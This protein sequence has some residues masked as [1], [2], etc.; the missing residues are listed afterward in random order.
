MASKN[1]G[2][3]AFN[4]NLR[5]MIEKAKQAGMTK[6]NIERAIKRG[7]GELGGAVFEEVIYEIY[8]PGGVGIIVEAVTDNKNRIV[9]DLRSLLN[10]YNGKL[11]NSGSVNFLFEKQGIITIKCS[12]KERD[13]IS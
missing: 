9:A 6:E 2:D 8:G 12:S 4:P 1:G 5:L 7:T 13:A 10:K 3:P 11:A